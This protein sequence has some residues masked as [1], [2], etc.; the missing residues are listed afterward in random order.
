[1][2]SLGGIWG[3]ADLVLEILPAA[4][5]PDPLIFKFERT[6]SAVLAIQHYVTASTLS[7]LR[8][9][10]QIWYSYLQIGNIAIYKGLFLERSCD[11]SLSTIVGLGT[12]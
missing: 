11:S 9:G 2:C 1:M 10:P 4:R 5:S 6:K 7:D 12:H 3:S 8:A